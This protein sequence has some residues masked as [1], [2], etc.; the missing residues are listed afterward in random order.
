[1]TRVGWDVGIIVEQPNTN[2]IDV[3]DIRLMLY[4]QAQRN[5]ESVRRVR[6]NLLSRGDANI[7]SS[8]SGAD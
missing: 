5:V 2:L 1:L 4:W 8:L 7:Q 3:D 6:R